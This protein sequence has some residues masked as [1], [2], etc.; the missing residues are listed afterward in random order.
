M[1]LHNTESQVWTIKWVLCPFNFA[2][3]FAT[4]QIVGRLIV[5]TTN[6]NISTGKSKHSELLTEQVIYR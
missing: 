3:F 1:F 5:G 4:V 2:D 6:N